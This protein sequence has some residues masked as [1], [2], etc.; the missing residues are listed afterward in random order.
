[1][2]FATTEIYCTI[3]PPLSGD[4]EDCSIVRVHQLQMLYS[5][6]CCMS[7]SQCMFSSLWNVVLARSLAV[8]AATSLLTTMTADHP[9]NASRN[10]VQVWARLLQTAVNADVDPFYHDGESTEGTSLASMPLRA[11]SYARRR[12]S[13]FAKK[14]RRNLFC[15]RN[16][17]SCIVDW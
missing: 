15:S 9:R 4:V 10:D 12:A 6:W 3:S 11:L 5:R 7:A 17:W 13:A 16:C 1:M 14:A 8:A 2:S